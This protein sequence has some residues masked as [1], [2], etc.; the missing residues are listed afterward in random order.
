M[1]RMRSR[2]LTPDPRRDPPH[3]MTE[4]FE[5]IREYRSGRYAGYDAEAGARKS[6]AVLTMVRD[7]SVFFPIWLDYYSRFFA[8]EDIHVLDHE[9]TDGSTDG[10]GFVRTPVSHDSIDHVWMVEQIRDYQHTLLERYDVV[11]V[12]DVDEIIAPNP[13]MGTLGQY[14]DRF[15]EEFVNCIGYEL[16]HMHLSEPPL[17][18]GRPILAQRSRWFANDG[19]DKP[20]LS[21]T[22]LEWVPGF[23]GRSDGSFN[24]DPDL[25]LIHLHRMDYEICRQ[26]HMLRD[27]RQWAA[28]DLELRWATH[29]RLTGGEEFDRWFYEDTSTEGV[30][31][32]IEKIPTEW[33]G[34]F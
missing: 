31:M 19:Y 27:Q 1:E 28:Q 2:P 26:R 10:T 34:M 16:L 33:K 32:V 29:N 3:P 11:L 9:T 12:V 24:P 8:A 7:E 21:R 20:V 17:D 15:D 30:E 5:V 13:E 6:R 23:H 18:L 14:I 25:R 4:F 22:P